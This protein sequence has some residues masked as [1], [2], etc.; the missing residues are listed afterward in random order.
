LAGA[1]TS[2]ACAQVPEVS[3]AAIACRFPEVSS[4][5]PMAVQLPTDEHEIPL[6]EGPVALLIAL[7]GAATAVACAHVP[8]VSVAAIACQNPEVST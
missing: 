6:S 1:V 2:V 5:A 4:Y 7:A 8:E 3:V